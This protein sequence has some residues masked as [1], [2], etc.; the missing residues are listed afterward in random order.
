MTKAKPDKKAKREKPPKD[1][2][3]DDSDDSDDEEEEEEVESKH[4]RLKREKGRKSFMGLLRTLLSLIPIAM[5]LS[6]Q[7]FMVRPRASGVNALKLRPLELAISHAVHWSTTSPTVIRNPKIAKYMNETA[8]VLLIPHEWVAAR[9]SKRAMPNEQTINGAYKKTDKSFKRLVDKDPHVYEMVK[10]PFP[11]LSLIGSYLCLAGALLCP[12]VASVF[13][14]AIV[15]GCIL[16]LQGGRAFGMEAQPEL[17]VCGAGAVF[18]ILA[19]EAANSKPTAT[20]P[21]KRR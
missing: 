2:P 13:E 15:V 19:M 11:N 9:Q 3:S 5:V 6:K 10:Q 1:E 17:Y 18:M 12:L 7:P 4:T 14:Y 21:K 16:V 8:R 20:A